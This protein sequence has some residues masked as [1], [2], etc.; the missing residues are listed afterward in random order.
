MNRKY[1]SLLTNMGLFFLASFIPKTI[2]FFMVPLYTYCLTTEDY[3]TADLLTTT[4]QLLVPILTLQIQDSVLRF[5]MENG[6]DNSEVFSVGFLSVLRGGAVLLMGIVICKVLDLISLSI[7]Q[8]GYV[9]INYFTVSLNAIFSYFC[10]GIGKI[11]ILTLSSVA[12]SLVTVSTNILFL[13]S[14]DMGLDGYL[15]ANSLGA[16][17]GILIIF[18]GEK[19]YKYISCVKISKT[20]R[21]EMMVFSIPMILSALSWWINNASDR[22]I[23]RFFT[24][25]SFVGIFAVASKVPTIL[26]T[27]SAVVS[28]AYSISAIQEFNKNDTDGFLGRSYSLISMIM[29]LGCSCLTLFNV[30]IARI[31]FSKDFFQAWII[32]PPLLISSLMNQLS[33][34]CENLFIATKNTKIISITAA[35]AACI[36]TILNFTLIPLLGAYGAAVATAFGFSFQWILRYCFL[37]K[38]IKLKNNIKK[39]VCSYFLLIVQVGFAYFGNTY[40]GIQAVLLLLIVLFYR[41]ELIAMAK[42]PLKVL[43]RY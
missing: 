12:M 35:C 42:I 14:L 31:L 16:T 1:K 36:N 20:L 30:E 13:I 6:K 24:G 11:K 5:A 15:I 17:T 22:Y 2:S 3:G 41:R 29:V 23:L 37:R 19:L 18:L 4:V 38:E 7:L 39:E 9:V 40:I 33:L 27:M 34:S 25:V 32:V 8:W 26:S 28:R 21:N 43:H 10:R